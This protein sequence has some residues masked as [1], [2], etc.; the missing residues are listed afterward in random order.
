MKTIVS[1]ILI[2]FAYT[3]FAQDSLVYNWKHYRDYP[4]AEGEVWSVDG[5]ENLFISKGSVIQK[6]DSSGQLKFTQ[7]IKSLGEMTQ[8]AVIN[9]MKLVHFSVDQQTLCYFDNTLTASEDCIDL[10]DH[11]IYYGTKVATS[12]RS[13]KIWVYDN[14]NTSLRL[15]DIEGKKQQGVEVINLKGVLGLENISDIVE[16]Y[17]Q[18]YILDSLKGLYIFDMYGSL[19]DRIEIEGCTA[20]DANANAVFLLRN[21]HLISYTL[22]GMKRQ[23]FDLPVK[24]IQDFSLVNQSFFL[25]SSEIVYKYRLQISE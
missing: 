11:D 1:F 5:L 25:R 2:S 13:D 6:I 19:L 17:N 7:S 8:F 3:S 4:V 23:E 22:K 21:D 12:T 20:V 16:R 10:S 24:E 15:L 18:L 14:V 9:T